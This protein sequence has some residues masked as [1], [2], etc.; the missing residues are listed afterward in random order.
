MGFAMCSYCA[1]NEEGIQILWC[2]HLLEKENVLL[3]TPDPLIN[4]IRPQAKLTPC[5]RNDPK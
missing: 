2:A 5:G 4:V 3:L 1:C